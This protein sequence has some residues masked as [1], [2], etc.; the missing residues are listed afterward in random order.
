MLVFYIPKW[1]IF[2]KII[3][4]TKLLINSNSG[5]AAFQHFPTC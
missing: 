5:E 1:K 2:L 4:F 3:H